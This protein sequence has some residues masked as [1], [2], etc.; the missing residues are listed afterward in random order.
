MEAK[1]HT[2]NGKDLNLVASEK[3]TYTYDV[4]N[5]LEEK[6]GWKK[7][8]MRLSHSGSI[9]TEKSLIVCCSF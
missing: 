3:K 5:S 1:I 7:D 8:S 2:F 4:L 9:L 6:Y